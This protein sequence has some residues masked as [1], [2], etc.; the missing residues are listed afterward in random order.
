MLQHH[1]LPLEG[2]VGTASGALGALAFL[3]YIANVLQG[4]SSPQRA[5]W[6][7]W[8]TISTITFV[9][10]VFEGAGP[11]LWFVGMQALGTTT[12]FLLSIFCGRGEYLSQSDYVI[13]SAAAIGIA[14]W[15]ATENPAWSLAMNIAISA[16]GGSVTILKAYRRPATETL[17]TW[18]LLFFSAV[19]GLAATGG[20]SWV[21]MAYPLYLATLY[22]AITVAMLSGRMTTA[23]LR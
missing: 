18:V 8:A 15:L 1:V 17:A 10:L 16:L 12:I 4:R 3:P 11:S 21:L 20:E 5:S 7:I 9:S 6:L 2:S 14:L 19:L 22:G 13:L 23:A